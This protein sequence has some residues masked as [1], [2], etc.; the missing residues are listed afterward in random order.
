M[1]ERRLNL[2][3]LGFLLLCLAIMADAQATRTWVSGVGDDA[4]PCSRTAPCKTF[5]GAISKT[6]ASGEINCLDP[7]GY[8]GVTITKSITIDCTSTLG[9]ILAAGMNGITVNNGT[10]VVSIRGLDING[11]STGLCGIKVSAAARVYIENTVIDGFTQSGIWVE[12][13]GDTKVLIKNAT[14]KNNVVDGIYSVP[15]GTADILVV[16]SYLSGNGNGIRADS[17]AIV[18]VSGSSVVFNGSGFVSK[19][20]GK[21]ISLQNNIVDGNG[22]NGVPTSTL[23][24]Q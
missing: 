17:N 9:G 5:A 3:F 7:A 2:L 20:D 19:T 14:I 12:N 21:I 4:N 18:R 10:A 6:A 16:D 8:G 23:I 13:I 24:L 1:R 22:K 15:K 11:A